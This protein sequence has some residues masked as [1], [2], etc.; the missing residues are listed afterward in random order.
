MSLSSLTIRTA[1]I[2]AITTSV[3]QAGVSDRTVYVGYADGDQQA[4]GGGERGNGGGERV[5]EEVGVDQWGEE[6]G[7]V[8]GRRWLGCGG[9]ALG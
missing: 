5:D 9:T 3:T 7:A 1:P 6:S 2:V 8:G 4:V